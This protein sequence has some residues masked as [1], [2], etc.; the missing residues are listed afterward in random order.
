MF[1]CPCFLSCKDSRFFLSNCSLSVLRKIS[2]ACFWDFSE[3]QQQKKKNCLVISRTQRKRG[4]RGRKKAEEK[5]S[6]ALEELS[7][8]KKELHA[9]QCRYDHSETQR[10]EVGKIADL[11]KDEIR[12]FQQTEREK[13]FFLSEANKEIDR[14]VRAREETVQEKERQIAELKEQI[15]DLE[16]EFN[17]LTNQAVTLRKLEEDH[18]NLKQTFEAKLQ[19]SIQQKERELKQQ[20]A[21]VWLW[22]VS[23]TNSPQ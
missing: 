18:Q 8:L 12:Q 5:D 6:G 13:D 3:T 19:L 23:R 4:K 22:L 2:Q 7:S 17:G 11:L 21:L 10:I 14:L 20:S 1:F 9:L 16:K 15:Q